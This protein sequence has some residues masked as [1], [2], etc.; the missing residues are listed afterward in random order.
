MLEIS[1]RRNPIV[2]EYRRLADKRTPEM[3]DV[4][5]DGSRL[6]SEA[7]RAGVRIRQAA[8]TRQVLDSPDGAVLV[9]RLEQSGAEVVLVTEAVIAALSPTR[10][11]SGMVAIGKCVAADIA[12]ALERAPQLALV[13]AHI[14]DPGNAG[15]VVRAA[16]AF[17][18]TC[19]VFCGASVDPYGWKALR[20][21]MG[22]A[23]R[24]PLVPRADPLEVIRLLRQ[25][26]VTVLAAVPVGGQ[27]VTELDLRQPVSFLLGSEGRGLVPA[28]VAAADAR[29]TLPMA[30][31]VES[32]NVAVAAAVLAWEVWRQRLF[33]RQ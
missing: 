26:G 29:V 1:S 33:T 12:R 11:P 30:A 27:A 22:S 23:F 15:A 32:L 10:S 18:A 8:V 31:P 19:V 25:A 6:I 17:G 28:L 16:D 5:L 14:Q 3:T 9:E 4:L 13:L 24:V 20:G 2:A 21:S 7:V